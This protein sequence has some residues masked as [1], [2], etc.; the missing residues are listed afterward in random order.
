M[1][2]IDNL[3][4]RWQNYWIGYWYRRNKCPIC[5]E[6]IEWEDE[7]GTFEHPE[8]LPYPVHVDEKQ[9]DECEGVC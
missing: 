7:G 5:K 1:E 3:R 4:Q 2:I 8:S 6:P 9:G